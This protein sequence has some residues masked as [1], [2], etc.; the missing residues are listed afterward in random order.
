MYV[1]GEVELEYLA[2]LVHCFVVVLINSMLS[3]PC[4]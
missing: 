3:Q 4:L 1:T 2:M